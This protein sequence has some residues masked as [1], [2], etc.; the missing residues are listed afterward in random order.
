MANQVTKTIPGIPETIS[1]EKYVEL[2]EALGIDPSA[3][4]SLRLLRDG[5][6]CEVFAKNDGRRVIISHDPDC[7]CPSPAPADRPEG[8]LAPDC[9]AQHGF[10]K[11]TIF[12]P[13]VNPDVEGA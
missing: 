4:C 5:I 9:H 7:V 3:I 13:V 6:E 11:H 10:A 8:Y 12:I 2:I 1:R